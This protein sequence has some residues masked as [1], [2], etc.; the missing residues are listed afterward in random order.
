MALCSSVRF[1]ACFQDSC[2]NTFFI[3]HIFCLLN[4]VKTTHNLKVEWCEIGDHKMHWSL[5]LKM[6]KFKMCKE[7]I[8]LLTCFVF[9]D[10]LALCNHWS[11]SV[12]PQQ[13]VQRLKNN[14]NFCKS[15]MEVIIRG[16]SLPW[17]I[18]ASKDEQ[19][20]GRHTD[21]CKSSLISTV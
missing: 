8:I 19:L 18:W 3:L 12:F 2:S 4:P 13:M 16:R 11:T 15:L 6:L 1:W 21:H 17:K 7:W 10:S 5:C 9:E 20:F 14:N